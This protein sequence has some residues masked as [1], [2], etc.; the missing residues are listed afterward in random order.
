MSLQIS[1]RGLEDVQ[2]RL[3]DDMNN[4]S[5]PPMVRSMRE[6]VLLVYRTARV[7]APVDTGRLRASITPEVLTPRMRKVR[8]IVGSNVLY[9]PYMEL[10]TGTFAGRPA[11]RPPSGALNLWAKRHAIP[12]GGFVVAQGI[13]MRG[14]LKPR[15]FLQQALELNAARIFDML[16]RT[17]GR[18][19]T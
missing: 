12:G 2:D 9:A 4:L 10:G 16:G 13:G 14:G 6:A 18:I 5:G 3:A 11:H 8:G 17:V 19:I 7:L 1:V 15:R